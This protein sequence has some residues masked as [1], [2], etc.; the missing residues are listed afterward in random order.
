LVHVN[1]AAH[2]TAIV[3]IDFGVPLNPVR[4]SQE[5]EGVLADHLRAAT[6]AVLDREQRIGFYRDTTNGIWWSTSV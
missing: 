6:L 1:G 2:P 3:T 4:L 5:E